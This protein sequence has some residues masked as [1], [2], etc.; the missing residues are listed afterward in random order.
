MRPWPGVPQDTDTVLAVGCRQVPLLIENDIVCGLASL[1]VID[2]IGI[3]PDQMGVFGV[4]DVDCLYA[5]TVPREEEEVL[6]PGVAKMR[7]C[8]SLRIRHRSVG[9]LGEQIGRAHV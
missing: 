3:G 7:G 6:A 2:L 9:G 4:R 5:K 8:G 1:S